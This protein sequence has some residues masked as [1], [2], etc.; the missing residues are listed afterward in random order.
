MK[1][2][3]LLYEFETVVPEMA[4]VVFWSTTDVSI[5]NVLYVRILT[6]GLILVAD[7]S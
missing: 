2:I 4:W 6:V 5:A 3:G 1:L 7:V